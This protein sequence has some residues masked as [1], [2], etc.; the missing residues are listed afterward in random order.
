MIILV[1]SAACRSTDSVYNI[2]QVAHMAE[3]TC[4][5]L[6]AWTVL[7]SHNV[8]QKLIVPLMIS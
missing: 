1:G 2:F 7:N 6:Q 8:V 3:E 5:Q 4:F